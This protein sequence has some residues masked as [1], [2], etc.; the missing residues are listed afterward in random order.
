MHATV[1][2]LFAEVCIL[3]KTKLI[4]NNRSASNPMDKGACNSANSEIQT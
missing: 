1:S 3:R 2:A 4:V